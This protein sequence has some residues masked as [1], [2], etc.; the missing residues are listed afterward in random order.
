MEERVQ[1]LAFAAH[2]STI[3]KNSCFVFENGNSQISHANCFNQSKSDADGEGETYR[4]TRTRILR[5]SLIQKATYLD[6]QMS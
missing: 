6:H 5:S 1:S 4:L 3:V 2:L